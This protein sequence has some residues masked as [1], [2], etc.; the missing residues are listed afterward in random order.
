MVVVEAAAET[1]LQLYAG[2]LGCVDGSVNL[3]Q[4]IIDRLLAEDV[5]ACVSSLDDVL[6]MGVGRGA[7]ETASISGSFTIARNARRPMRPNP[8]M[9]TLIAMRI[10]FQ[11]L[12]L[13]I[14]GTP[15]S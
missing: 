8:L 9:P 1:D 6:G 13:R 12:A 11:I 3:L 15:R 10:P 14:A 4:I 7:D 2:F 5:L